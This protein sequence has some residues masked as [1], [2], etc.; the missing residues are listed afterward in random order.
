MLL[1]VP[2]THHHGIEVP[3]S[4]DEPLDHPDGILS[5]G[6]LDRLFKIGLSISA[7]ICGSPIDFGS[8][9]TKIINKLR[10]V[11]EF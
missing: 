7:N 8:E 9:A 6:K 4:S 10:A 1:W 3:P 5:L 2:Y 11:N